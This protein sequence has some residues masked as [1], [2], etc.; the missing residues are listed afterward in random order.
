MIAWKYK[1]KVL[2]EI[3]E[4][5]VGFIYRI[6]FGDGSFYIGQKS[7]YSTRRT[8][9][10]GKKNRKVTVKESNW[11]IYS[12]SSATVKEKITNGDKYNKN[13]IYFCESKACMN[14]HEAY[15]MFKESVLC[16]PRALNKNI[17]LKLFHCREVMDV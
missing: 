17:L 13:I 7:F 8:K 15:E 4:G 5:A 10:A 12:S 1:G 16:N 14:Y 6:E 3:P 2:T 11:R 9:V